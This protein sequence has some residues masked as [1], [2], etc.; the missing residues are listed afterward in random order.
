MGGYVQKEWERDLLSV[1]DTQKIRKDFIVVKHIVASI[2][3]MGWRRPG[4]VEDRT[5]EVREFHR[6]AGSR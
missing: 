3:N 2:R 5:Y 6:A 1:E 4:R